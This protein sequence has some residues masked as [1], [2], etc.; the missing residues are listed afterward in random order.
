[1]NPIE[2]LL[3]RLFRQYVSGQAVKLSAKNMNSC[4]ILSC[5]P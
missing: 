5:Q 1:M 3:D 2:K 4:S